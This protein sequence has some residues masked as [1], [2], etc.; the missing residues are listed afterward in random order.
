MEAHGSMS[1]PSANVASEVFYGGNV[2]PRGGSLHFESEKRI[3]R[4]SGNGHFITVVDD[5]R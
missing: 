1:L 5:G 3:R 2:Q 4:G